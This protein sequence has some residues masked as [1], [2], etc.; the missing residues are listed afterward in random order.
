M[1]GVSKRAKNKERH[2]PMKAAGDLSRLDYYLKMQLAALSDFIEYGDSGC[3]S[4]NS[5]KLAYN[6][7]EGHERIKRNE[8]A[9]IVRYKVKQVLK[10]LEEYYTQYKP[11]HMDYIYSIKAQYKDL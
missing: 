7:E 2:K 8:R 5:Y 4:G 10:E 11:E 1:P 6:N 3:C 9:G